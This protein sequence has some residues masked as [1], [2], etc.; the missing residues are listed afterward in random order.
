MV[1]LNIG[2]QTQPVQRSRK[3]KSNISTTNYYALII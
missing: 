1:D 3:V 2:F